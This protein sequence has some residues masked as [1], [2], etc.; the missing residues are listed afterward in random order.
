MKTQNNLLNY[1]IVIR[2]IR[3]IKCFNFFTIAVLGILFI[4]NS[5]MNK[6]KVDLIV[7][8]AS[9]QCVNETMDTA[10]AMAISNGKIIAI[11]SS[12]QILETYISDSIVNLYNK[13]VYPGLIDAHCH[14]YGYA[15][16]KREAQLY[17]TTS[18][19][20]VV[21]VLKQHSN[22]YP[23]EYWITGRGWDQNKWE[24]KEFPE[25]S[26][27]DNVFPENPVVI[28]RIDGHACLANTKALQLAGIDNK[29]KIR[30]GKINENKGH[31]TGILLD[32]ACDSMRNVIPLPDNHLIENY[33]L[34][35]QHDL[36]AVGLTS[37]TDAGNDKNIIDIFEKLVNEEKL[38]IGIYAMLHPT[39]DNIETFVKKGIYR[40]KN[41]H[42]QSIKL[43]SDG[44][45]G[46]RGA[47]LLSPYSD[48]KT[49]YGLIVE[50]LSYYDSIAKLAYDNGYQ[51]NIHAI[52]DSAVRLILDV[53]AR[54]LKKSN[55][56]RW[57]IEHSQVVHPNDI[58]KYGKYSIVPAINTTHA[59]S[60][61]FWAEKRIGSQRIK[62]AYAYKDLLLQNN[63]LCNGSDFPI[64][65]INPLLGFY[66][67]ITRKDIHGLPEHGFN[68]ENGLTRK[69]ALKAMTLWAAKAA[70]EENIRGSLEVGKQADFIVL[71]DNLLRM[72]ARKIPAMKINSTYI[73]GKE[74]FSKQ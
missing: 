58:D 66:A 9:I 18:F 71:D 3:I 70:F 7:H 65:S 46:S 28:F 40:N 68:I 12:K 25:N 32:K 34:E 4:M 20:D 61:M 19:N 24:L 59:T 22:K 37:I 56:L 49:N 11:G 43:Y 31:L 38:I 17:Q 55:D 5:C 10:E 64:E 27:L 45:L 73:N 36:F 26:L 54:Q 1:S 69:E 41:L 53:Y 67:A 21:E 23:N 29:T 2:A 52:G 33:L 63:W 14:F 16:S 62:H 44:A 15:L 48:D 47:A 13:F 8:N 50:E 74:V 6:E 57:R 51:L 42:I 39:K 60:D 72:D 30:G 35:A